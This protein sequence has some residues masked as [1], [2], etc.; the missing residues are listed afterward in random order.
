VAAAAACDARPHE[1]WALAPRTR[2]TLDV[3]TR[4]DLLETGAARKLSI[5]MRGA[6]ADD[7][8]LALEVTRVTLEV[9]EPNREV[10]RTVAPRAADEAGAAASPV[11]EA[12]RGATVR[13]GLDRSAGVTSVAGLDLAFASAGTAH[14]DECAALSS[15]ASDAAW[16]RDLANAGMS[17]VPETLRQGAAVARQARVRIAGRG[18]T[19]AQLAGEA[20]R[21]NRGSPATH[22]AGRLSAD[23]VFEGDGGPTPPA[24]VGAV[25]L[26]DVT[27]EATTSYAGDPA[28]PL[29]GEWIVTTLFAGGLTVRTT[30]SFAL[31]LR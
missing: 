5:A 19:S 17:A 8:S 28:L 24:D 14:R 15:L 31:V 11:L 23:A 9:R 18:V 30:T 21:D 1:P 3:T 4:E 20:A 27:L 2:V 26:A 29:R 10:V 22:V 13:V 7:G 25:R 16:A 6:V 12:L